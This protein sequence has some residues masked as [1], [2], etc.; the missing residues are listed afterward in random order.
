MLT[1]LKQGNSPRKGLKGEV[2]GDNGAVSGWGVG[3]EQAGEA[4]MESK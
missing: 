1:L 2:H 4:R 3:V